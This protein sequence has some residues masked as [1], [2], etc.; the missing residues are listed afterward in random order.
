MPFSKDSRGYLWFR[1][2]V[3]IEQVRRLFIQV[4]R[5]M[6]WTLA[7]LTD[8]NVQRIFRGTGRQIIYSTATGGINIYDPLTDGLFLV[9]D[10]FLQARHLSRYG[11]GQDRHGKDDHDYFVL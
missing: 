8:G 5:T 11:L 1:Y 9:T 2:K 3:R 4:F 6:T 10:T 7:S